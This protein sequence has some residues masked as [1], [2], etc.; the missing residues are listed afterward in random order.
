M[1]KSKLRKKYK[2]IRKG[3][4]Y[5][6]FSLKVAELSEY[7]T[8]ETVFVYVSFDDEAKTE[9]LILKAL[10]EKRVVV[11]YCV[12][13]EGTMIACEIKSL[14]DLKTGNFGI[15]E[16]INPREYKGKIDFSVIPGLAF[17]KDGYRLGYGKGYYDRFLSKIPCLKVGLTFDELTVD[18]LPY[19]EYD[20]KVD[21]IITPGKEIYI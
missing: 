20:K 4:S 14:K 10:F 15:K 18:T 19:D 17:S 9:A 8:A 11:P 13:K 3:L 1:D 16:P 7:K 21:V 12:D 2:E 6:D 5:G